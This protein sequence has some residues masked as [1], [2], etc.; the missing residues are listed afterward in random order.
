MFN[1]RIKQI[2]K[3]IK[4]SPKISVKT[5]FKTILIPKPAILTQTAKK[6]TKRKPW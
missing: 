1:L 3:L 6:Q 5:I 2:I 4:I